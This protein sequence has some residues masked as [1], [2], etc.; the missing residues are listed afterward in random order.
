SPGNTGRP[1]P[2]GP[3]QGGL[4]RPGGRLTSFDPAPNSPVVPPTEPSCTAGRYSTRYPR[5]PAVGGTPPRYKLVPA[6]RY[7]T[8]PR[9][10]PIAPAHVAVVV[11]RYMLEVCQ[12]ACLSLRTAYL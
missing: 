4:C 1:R 12:F 8:S 2:Q 11:G 7:R 9:P 3:P 5:L 10:S 6:R